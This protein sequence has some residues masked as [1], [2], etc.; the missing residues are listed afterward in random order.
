MRCS[1]L[2]VHGRLDLRGRHQRHELHIGKN[3]QKH[4]LHVRER[5]DNHK[6]SRETNLRS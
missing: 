3:N 4:E 1:I 6:S 2:M 5:L